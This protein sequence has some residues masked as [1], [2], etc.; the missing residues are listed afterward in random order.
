MVE[1]EGLSPLGAPDGKPDPAL[2]HHRNVMK[3]RLP[4][5]A[6]LFVDKRDGVNDKPAAEW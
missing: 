5:L 2:F 4:M 3:A 1:V 6:G